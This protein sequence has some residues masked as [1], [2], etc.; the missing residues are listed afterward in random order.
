ME[1]L[2]EISIE[3]SLA[4]LEQV[5]TKMEDKDC[6]LEESFQL[7]KEG[8][9]LVQSCR[10]SLDTVEQQLVVLREGIQDGI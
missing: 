6:S 10:K 7:Y 2:K 4:L 8:L 9:S 5:L 3:E 1:N